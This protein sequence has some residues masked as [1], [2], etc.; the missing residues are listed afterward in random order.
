[1]IGYYLMKSI[2]ISIG[3]ELLIG[4]VINTNAAFIAQKLNSIGVEIGRVLTVGDSEEEI[5]KSFREGFDNFDIVL[6]T[7]GLGPTH[8]DITRKA[9]CVFFN[10]DLVSNN[11]VREHIKQL[12]QKRNIGWTNAAEDQ[13]LVPRIATVIP[14]KHGTAPGTL[15]EKDNKYF[16][17][18]PGVP[19]EM[20]SMVEDFVL[21][22]FQKKSRGHVVL[23]RTLNT[24]GIPE[25]FLSERLGNLETLLGDTTLAF[26]PSPSGVRL[27]ISVVGN[28]RQLCE[29]KIKQIELQ[30]RVKA[31]KFIYGSDDET[32]EE[33]IG[34]L[35]TERNLTIAVA[36]SCTGGMIA[37]RITNV[38][39]SSNYFERGVITYSNRSKTELLHVPPELI[40]QHGAVSKEVALAMA[41]G[42]RLAAGTSIGLSTT[43]I[44]GPT[45]GSAEKP[46]GLVWI[47]YSDA[48]ESLA[49][50]FNLGDGR[51]R[52]KERAAQAALD[53]IRRKLLQI[54]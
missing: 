16:I 47:G 11:E 14:N 12:M 24:T 52:V 49:L 17:S 48:K 4:Q 9:I 1:M 39:G 37:H 50:K 32:L 26:L 46:V 54:E 31:G 34:K 19:Y 30:I 40:E 29:S 38:S 5:L 20:E 6:V 3:D 45:G 44:A 15:I 27:R 35:L 13:T 10:T 21:P 18:M 23:H 28:D 7:G 43:G 51:V 25:S 42:V 33:V 22:Y 8:D 36:E 41:S 53:I 2:I